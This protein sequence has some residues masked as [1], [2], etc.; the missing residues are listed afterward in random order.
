MKSGNTWMSPEKISGK[1]MNCKKWTERPGNLKQWIKNCTQE[2]MLQL[3]WK[4]G[5]KGLIGCENS[6]KSEKMA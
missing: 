2:V 3:H 1:R 5:G 6:V 4:N